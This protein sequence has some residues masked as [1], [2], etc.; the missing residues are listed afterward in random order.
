V[1]AVTLAASLAAPA[2]GVAATNAP[3]RVRITNP[4][5]DTVNQ[6]APTV[7]VGDTFTARASDRDGRVTR[8]EWFFVHGTYGFGPYYEPLGVS[9]TAPYRLTFR[10]PARLYIGGSLLARAYDNSGAYTDATTPI[11][12]VGSQGR[13]SEEVRF[14]LPY[15]NEAE[16]GTSL[17]GEGTT[18]VEGP[19]TTDDETRKLT[20][21]FLGYSGV[22]AIGFA[23]AGGFVQWPIKFRTDTS[24]D[25][26]VPAG[27]YRLTWRYNNPSGVTRSLRLT[28]AS[29]E[30]IYGKQTS[31]TDRGSVSFPAT[32]APTGQQAW[33][34]VSVTVTLPAGTGNI[35]LTST[36][37]TGPLLDYLVITPVTG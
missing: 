16:W 37:G 2:T 9:T 32:P 20:P 21:V 29:G 10:G 26:A 1:L 13:V 6:E 34:T 17:R 7:R 33:R 8:V 28:T 15:I 36:D 12:L 35:R 18:R 11:I 23:K 31:P 30:G 22:G 24:N 19:D 5:Y 27:A 14:A 25:D 3:P 4:V